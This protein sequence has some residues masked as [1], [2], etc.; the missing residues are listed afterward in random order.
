M[1]CF[2]KEKRKHGKEWTNS[3]NSTKYWSTFLKKYPPENF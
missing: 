2:R 1:T 3:A